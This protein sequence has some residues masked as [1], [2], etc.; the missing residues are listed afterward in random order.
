M[1]SHIAYLHQQA[2]AGDRHAQYQLAALYRR[3]V[4]RLARDDTKA[5]ALYVQAAR[6]GHLDAHYRLGLA[7]TDGWGV[8]KDARTAARWFHRAAR[9]GHLEAQYQMGLACAL[10]RGVVKDLDLALAWLRLAASRGHRWAL[11][12]LGETHRKGLPLPVVGLAREWHAHP[13]AG[14]LALRARGDDGNTGGGVR[15]IR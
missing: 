2:E 10:G 9:T 5:V 11:C 12:E 14:A 6:Q 1:V 13:E 8:D 7:Y 3:G 4:H 15:I